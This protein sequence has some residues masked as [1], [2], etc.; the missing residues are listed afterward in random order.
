MD[1]SL[2]DQLYDFDDAMDFLI[3]NGIWPQ[4]VSAQQL[5]IESVNYWPSSRAIKVDGED[6]ARPEKGLEALIA[7]LNAMGLA[8]EISRE[9]AWLSKE[10][11]SSGNNPFAQ[12]WRRPTGLLFS[13]SM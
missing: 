4:V 10:S 7:M 1:A 3:G 9:P 5:K 2:Q 8:D 11:C 6:E 12:E 13:I